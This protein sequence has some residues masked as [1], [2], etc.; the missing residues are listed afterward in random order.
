MCGRLIN[1][2]RAHLAELGIVAAQ[3]RNKN[4]AADAEAVWRPTMCFEQVK[5]VPRN[6]N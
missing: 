1:A 5:S 3:G 6:G 2:L 4:D